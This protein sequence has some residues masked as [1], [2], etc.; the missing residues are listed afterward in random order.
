MTYYLHNIIASGNADW[1]RLTIARVYRVFRGDEWKQNIN[2]IFYLKIF[3]FWSPVVSIRHA[4][5]K[6][7]CQKQCKVII[8][9]FIVWVSP[10]RN[11][12]RRSHNILYLLYGELIK[13]KTENQ[14][15]KNGLYSLFNTSVFYKRKLYRLGLRVDY[16]KK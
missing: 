7:V 2:I 14:T 3:D 16:Y 4:S 10:P 8:N 1:H 12:D 5:V 13:K 9:Y 11:R 6:N 15:V